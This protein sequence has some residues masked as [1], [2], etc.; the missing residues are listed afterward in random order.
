MNI[1]ERI[2]L[3]EGT[4]I[5]SLLP[6]QPAQH[7]GARWGFVKV[8][9]IA[10]SPEPTGALPGSLFQA[11]QTFVSGLNAAGC[12]W[13]FLVTG[14]AAGISVYFALPGPGDLRS[15]WE[16]RLSSCFPC[17]EFSGADDSAGIERRVSALGQVVILTGNPSVGTAGG[18]SPHSQG[19]TG[20]WLETLLRNMA[21]RHFAYV[22]LAR[23]VAQD[24]IQ[25]SFNWLASEERELV[26]NFQRRG[27]AEENNHPQARHCLELLRAARTNHQLGLSLGM[28]DVQVY[29]RTQTAADLFFGRQA[30]H[31]AFSGAGSRPQPIRVQP[32]TNCQRTGSTPLETRLNTVETVALT[33]LPEEESSGYQ[34]REYV[35]FAVSAPVVGAGAKVDIGTVLDG[36]KRTANW[37]SI[38]LTDLARHALVVGAS[39]SGKTNTCQHLLLQLW[40]EYRT[41]WL[42]IEPSMK[43]EYRRLLRSS[44]ADDLRIFTLGDESGVPFR[45]NPLEVVPGIQVQTQ[46]DGVLSLFGAAF[47]WVSPMPE[48]LSLAVHRLYL[49][50]GWDLVQGTHPK[51]YAQEAQPTLSDLLR[52]IPAFVQELGYNAEISSTIRAGLITR[53]SSLTSGGKGRMLNSGVSVPFDDL[54]SKPAILE[55][56]AIGNDEEKAFILGAILMRLAHHRQSAGL[57]DGR[58]QHVLLIEEAHRLLA[59]APAHS[60]SDMANPRAKAVETFCNLLAEVRAYGQGVVAAEQIP[61]KLVSDLLKNVNLKIVH[62]LP[63]QEDRSLVGGTMNLTPGHERFLATLPAGQAVVFAEGRELACHVA[64]PNTSFQL[65]PNSAVPTKAEVVQHMRMRL[66]QMPR[67]TETPGCMSNPSTHPGIPPCPGCASGGCTIRPAIL[68]AMAADNLAPGFQK[69]AGKGWD[70]LWDFGLAT[71]SRIAVNDKPQAAYCLLMNIAAF[72]RFG[73]AALEE[74]RT[75]LSRNRDSTTTAVQPQEIT[76]AQ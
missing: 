13:G 42:V 29:L 52:M 35:R 41:P 47:G 36:G 4:K 17:S 39:G 60:V 14:A 28:W 71:S 45:L 44:L 54:L 66:P 40:N 74:M 11:Q 7:F 69:A 26:S 12:P 1:I 70:V 15:I 56:S 64:M 34:V 48:V 43:S 25:G 8:L 38:P 3:L 72:G 58:L 22:V 73:E 55:L 27:S 50:C 76:H 30:L 16:P 61:S 33:K 51:G 49:N 37:F 19:L 75:N 62:R 18:E 6:Q 5:E 20:A 53:L 57:T 59:A 31:S 46:I 67:T 32:C 2:Q 68:R 24:V 10:R 21:G 9:S 63:A 23:P 65:R